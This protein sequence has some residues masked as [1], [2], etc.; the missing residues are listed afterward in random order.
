[1]HHRVCYSVGG[2]LFFMGVI[3]CLA[4]GTQLTEIP[5]MGM[6]VFQNQ[7]RFGYGYERVTEVPEV[8]GI[9]ARAYRMYTCSGYAYECPTE[10][11]EVPRTGNIRGNSR[12]RSRV[13]SI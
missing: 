2:M 11:S 10:L 9:V 7:Q 6:N 8:P 12:A 13:S 3:S 5:G 4:Y 1:M